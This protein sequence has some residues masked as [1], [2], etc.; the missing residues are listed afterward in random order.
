MKT[1]LIDLDGVLNEYDGSY[2]PN[3]IP[4]IK[5]G[6]REFLEELS[7]VYDI[8][9]FTSRPMKLTAKWVIENNLDNIISDITNIKTPSYLMI[10]DRTICHNGDFE[11]TLKN[12][13]EF[14]VHWKH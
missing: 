13:N 9:I 1:L 5:D 6:A 3:T 12:I 7:K 14:Q 10:D 8:K 11:Q 2:D 4:A